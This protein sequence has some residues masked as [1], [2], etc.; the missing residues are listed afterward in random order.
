MGFFMV[1]GNKIVQCAWGLGKVSNSLVEVYYL[2]CGL[3]IA[4][5]ESVRL[6]VI[7]GYST[8][9]IK[10]MIAQSNTEGNKLINLISRIKW[11]LSSFH[12]VTLLHIKQELNYEVDHWAKFIMDLSPETL[13]KNGDISY[14][15][16]P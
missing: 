7:F 15:P 10:S 3:S 11:E 8:L 12:K 9:V 14:F 16:I 5:G 6:V 13:L 1:E 2:W 4:K